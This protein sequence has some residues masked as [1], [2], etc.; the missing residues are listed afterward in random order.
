MASNFAA[1]KDGTYMAICSA[2]DVCK[3][4]NGVPAPFPITQKLST[5]KSEAKK[6]KINGK[7]AL[8]LKSQLPSVIGDE[9][10]VNKGVKS[11]SQGKKVDM[12]EHS[13]S[14]KVEGSPLVR[15]GD[16]VKMNNNNTIGSIVFAPKPMMGVIKDS[17]ELEWE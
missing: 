8:M 10:G 3:L 12:D 9:P 7:A 6:H 11:G 4:P 16:K 15:V 14:V 5:A 1:R 13:K 17:G 2:P